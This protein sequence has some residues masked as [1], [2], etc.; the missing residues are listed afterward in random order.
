M[1]SSFG[2]DREGRVSVGVKLRTTSLASFHHGA[3]QPLSICSA[4]E[5]GR[6]G[7]GRSAGRGLATLLAPAPASIATPELAWGATTG[8]TPDE[9]R[10]AD[11]F[12][13]G[14]A[15]APIAAEPPA[16]AAA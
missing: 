3:V 10:P 5:G 8:A 14:P 6:A 1:C 13:R 15:V 7:A 9:H 12:P 11:G 16:A 2:A 4:S